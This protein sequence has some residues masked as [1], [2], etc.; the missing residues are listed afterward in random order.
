MVLVTR[1]HIKFKDKKTSF[2]GRSYVNYNKENFINK[3]SNMDWNPIIL[4]NDVNY[5]WDL[6]IKR[7]KTI[8]DQTCPLKRFKVKV[9]NKPW[10]THKLIEQIKDKDRALKKAKKTQKGDDW[11]H[12][13]RLRNDCLKAV[14][15]AKS[16]FIKN[17]LN[18]H[19]KDPKKFWENITSILPTNSKTNNLIKLK[20]QTTHE[21]ICEEKTP[22][23][24]NE[25]LSGICDKLATKLNEPWSY[26]GL[27]CDEILGNCQITLEE[28]I[29]LIKEIDVT[30]SSI[31]AYLSS[32]VFKDAFTLLPHVLH[33]IFN[34]SLSTGIVPDTWKHVTI[35][36][37]KKCGN[38]NDVSNLRPISLDPKQGKLLEKIVHTRIM[39]HLEVNN[40]LDPKQGG[41]RA[42]HST[43][44]TISKFTENIYKGINEGEL[45][46]APYIDLKKAFDT[47]NHKILLQKLGKLGIQN[48]NLKWLRNYLS[49][50]SQST[51]ANGIL[52]TSNRITC[53][54]PQGSVL[55]PLLFVYVNDLSS[56]LSNSGQYLY[57]D[58]TVIYRS[59][60]DLQDT[61]NL[62]Q[63][64]L[65]SF[66]SWYKSNKLT[67]FFFPFF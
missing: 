39:E 26:K 55:G 9:T 43:T 34:L 28:V 30:K 3:L 5:S 18:T 41:F 1:R 65:N 16:N 62:L 58:D 12:A 59:G 67:F 31:V 49:N 17:E 40:L 51:L 23:Y 4:G 7:I 14:R 10:I 44:N 35:I 48:N 25:F 27:V 38:S 20:D 61:T 15:N 45:T 66:G 64:D 54:V 32:K 57:A 36:P 47:V 33:N 60:S 63:T 13:R 8:I 50:R 53:G 29:A 22:Q 11:V 21:I 52:S 56:I 6:L 37:L 42:N 46:I 24:I 19:A 2:I